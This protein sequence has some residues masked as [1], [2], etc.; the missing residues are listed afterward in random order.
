MTQINQI[1]TIP[2]IGECRV[3]GVVTLK[4]GAVRIDYVA[5]KIPGVRSKQ[6]VGSIMESALPKPMQFEPAKNMNELMRE[7]LKDNARRRQI[8]MID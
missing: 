1:I 3:T 8:M 7:H 6:V 4:S 2:G 5:D